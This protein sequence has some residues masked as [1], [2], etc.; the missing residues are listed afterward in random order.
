MKKR[1][2]GTTQSG[3]PITEYTFTNA[4]QVTVQIIN[5]GGII[6]AVHAPDR[7]GKILNVALGLPS[8][9]EYETHNPF[10]GC[11]AG[12]YANRIA[13]GQFTLDGKTYHLAINNG[14]NHLHG[15]LKD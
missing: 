9:R 13:K 11:I 1:L 2:Y 8:F 6:T 4:N 15:G 7:S 12:R 5:Y 3:Q 10:F 14:P